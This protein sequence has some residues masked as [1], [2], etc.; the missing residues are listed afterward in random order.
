MNLLFKKV[1]KELTNLW[2]GE[3]AAVVSFWGCFFVMKVWLPSMQ[4]IISIAYPLFILS[5]ILVQGSL[6]WWIL[7]KRLSIPQFAMKN[8]GKIF[9]ILKIVDII[10]LCTGLPVIIINYSNT[11]VMI[12]SIFLLGFAVAEWINYFKIRLAY[13]YNPFTLLYRIKD[14]KLKKSKLAKE[15]KM[16]PKKR[17][18]HS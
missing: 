2:T 7:L 1:K 3:L 8:T 14:R 18:S 6:Y 15:I 16:T 4:M 12:I 10:L 17:G 9:A 11:T 5:L 13:N